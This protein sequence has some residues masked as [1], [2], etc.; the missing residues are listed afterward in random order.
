MTWSDLPIDLIHYTS[1]HLPIVDYLRLFVVC[2]SWNYV[3]SNDVPNGIQCRPSPWL[4]LPSEAGEAS[5]SLTFREFTIKEEETSVGCHLRFSSLDSYI[6]G[7]RCFGSKDGWLMT[8]EKEDLQARLFNPL[9]KAEISFPSLFTIPKDEGTDEECLRDIYFQKIIVSSN[10]LSGTAIVIYG[11]TKSLALERLGDQTWVLGPQ[12]P[13]YAIMHVEQFE[14]VYYHQE[15]KRFY[16]I[17]HFSM[18]L[19]FDVNGKNLN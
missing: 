5:N 4:L 3:L 10:D 17:T 12:L 7:R 18:V 11:R 14:D 6:I 9:T 15:D 16:T 2:T 1:S 13:L 8:L 19:A